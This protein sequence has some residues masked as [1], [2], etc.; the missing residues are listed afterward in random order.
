MRRNVAGMS[1]EMRL[2]EIIDFC[3]AVGFQ[4]SLGFQPP[5]AG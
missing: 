3:A 5:V 4:E 2:R 1:F